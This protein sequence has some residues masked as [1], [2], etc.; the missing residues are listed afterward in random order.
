[1]QIKD[2]E[3]DNDVGWEKKLC[4][5]FLSEIIHS[6]FS[7]RSP[8]LF[9]LSPPFIILYVNTTASSSVSVAMRKNLSNLK[10]DALYD[11]LCVSKVS[12]SHITNAFLS[13]S[14]SLSLF[15]SCTRKFL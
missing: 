3:L 9:Y 10:A 11:I 5:C 15:Y 2:C 12:L 14:S 13:L 6:F 7:L 8:S 4:K 1:M